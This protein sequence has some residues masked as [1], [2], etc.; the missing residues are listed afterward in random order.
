MKHDITL[1]SL[2]FHHYG[3]PINCVSDVHVSVQVCHRKP[4]GVSKCLPLSISALRQDLSESEALHFGWLASS[5]YPPVSIPRCCSY[6]HT[7]PWPAFH[8]MLRT[9][10]QL[11]GLTYQVPVQHRAVSPGLTNFRRQN[12]KMKNKTLL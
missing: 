6:K 9:Q 10:T 7:Q 2:N 12:I 5:R 1:F 11:R 4:M 8:L 3:M